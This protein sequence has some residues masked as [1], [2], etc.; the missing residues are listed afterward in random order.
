LKIP[1][2]GTSHLRAWIKP[3]YGHA[4]RNECSAQYFDS[5]EKSHIVQPVDPFEPFEEGLV[6]RYR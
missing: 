4:G 3:L 1:A 6:A 5:D 2:G